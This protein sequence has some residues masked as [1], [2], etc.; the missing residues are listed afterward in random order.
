MAAS[1]VAVGPVAPAGGVAA[2]GPVNLGFEDGVLG[3]EPTGW[4]VGPDADGVTVVDEETGA[5]SP[6]YATTNTVVTPYNGTRMLRLGTPKDIAETQPADAT[7]V[8]QQFVVAD[9]EEVVV[10]ARIFSWEFR[11]IDRAGF[12]AD[13]AI[14]TEAV[15]FFDQDPTATPRT[16]A[17]STTSKVK[18]KD[19][20]P[21]P[22][23]CDITIAGTKG[24][25]LDSEWRVLHL[26]PIPDADA[27][28]DTITLAYT[29]EGTDN[30]SHATWAY[31]DDVN[32]PPVAQFTSEPPAGAL[33]PEGSPYNCA[34][35]RTTPTD[36]TT[37][38]NGRGPSRQ[39]PTGCW[40][41]TWPS[42]RRPR[43]PRSSRPTTASTSWS[44]RSRAATA[45]RTAQR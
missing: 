15:T 34:T 20:Y 10:A 28:P 9:G 11:D 24:T 4:T 25:L 31:F 32:H 13:G 35:R 3:G 41:T 33:I 1:L 40:R 21:D 8:S 14:L 7:T 36:L 43:T 44:S 5:D 37:S 19:V 17:A 12:L 2:D 26:A 16:C 38:S 42:A 29:V 27:L 39:S 30:S 23:M 18:G 22:W 45:P 6:T